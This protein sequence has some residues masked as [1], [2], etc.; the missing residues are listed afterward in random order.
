MSKLS[1]N[2]KNND[3]M[4]NRYK[5]D[6]IKVKFEGND[7]RTIIQNLQVI[8]AQIK[9]NSEHLMKNFGYELNT[10]CKSHCV[11]QGKFEASVLQK[12]LYDFI[13]T[14]VLCKQCG[15]PEVTMTI[16]NGKSVKH[17]CAAC[18]SSYVIKSD[19]KIHKYLMTHK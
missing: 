3:D 7:T 4:F 19:K 11:L 18:G 5:M 2:P 17:E 10:L 9:V 1:I 13:K 16:S 15:L 14:Y 6:P 8:A 12:I